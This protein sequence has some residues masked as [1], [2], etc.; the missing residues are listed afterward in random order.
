MPVRADDGQPTYMRITPAAHPTSN[1][2]KTLRRS[3]A[4]RKSHPCQNTTHVSKTLD[5]SWHR[6]I[7][8]YLIFEIDKSFVLDVDESLEDLPHRH[9]ALS[10]S[11]LTLLVLEACQIFDVQIEE[12]LSVS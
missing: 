5:N 4:V 9:H 12:P 11:D 3:N 10:H 7:G 2:E 8:V 1:F 6:V